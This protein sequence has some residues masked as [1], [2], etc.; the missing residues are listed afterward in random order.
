MTR[1]SIMPAAPATGLA[2][3]SAEPTGVSLPRSAKSERGWRFAPQCCA[4]Q[5]GRWRRWVQRHQFT[6]ESLW[7]PSFSFPGNAP[8][9]PVASSSCSEGKSPWRASHEW[10]CRPTTYHL[11]LRCVTQPSLGSLT[12]RSRKVS[13]LLALCS[14]RQVQFAEHRGVTRESSSAHRHVAGNHHCEE[15]A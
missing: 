10:G 5:S 13:R 3:P 2:Q 7:Q 1:A 6:L 4:W 11:S 12:P 8:S 9:R 14:E 15:G